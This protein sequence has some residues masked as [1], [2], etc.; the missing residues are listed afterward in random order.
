MYLGTEVVDLVGSEG[1]RGV[2]GLWG[3]M[4][5]M[6][7]WGDRSGREWDGNLWDVGRS[8]VGDRGVS[9]CQLAARV[10]WNENVGGKGCGG[11]YVVHKFASRTRTRLL[12]IG[13]ICAQVRLEL[14]EDLEYFL[15]F[16]AR[17][18]CVAHR[19][20]LASTLR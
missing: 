9:I 1:D 15:E 14:G 3:W 2:R 8:T 11:Q 18:G 13:G 20:E 12:R 16:R 19:S 17:L 4:G 5:W 7:A 6:V 10:T